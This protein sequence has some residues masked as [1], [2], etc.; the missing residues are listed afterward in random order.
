[1][2][3]LKTKKKCISTYFSGNSAFQCCV[4]CPHVHSFRVPI[5]IIPDIHFCF[6]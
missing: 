1:M 2:G 4:P 5:V 3:V 6:C